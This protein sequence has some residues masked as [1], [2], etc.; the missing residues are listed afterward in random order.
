MQHLQHVF[1]QDKML[2]PVLSDI[3]LD[4]TSR[5]SIVIE[6]CDAAIYLEGRHVE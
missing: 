1:L 4:C 2:A 5:R 6:A 3:L